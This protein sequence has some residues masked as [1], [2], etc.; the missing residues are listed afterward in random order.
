MT[1]RFVVSSEVFQSAMAAALLAVSVAG[2]CKKSSDSGEVPGTP[3]ATAP[4]ASGVAGGSPAAAEAV[5]PAVQVPAGT[6]VA[7]TPCQQIPRITNEELEGVRLELNAF[8]IDAYPYPNDPGKPPLTNV[9]RDEAE[10]LCSARGRRL[11]TELEWE[12]ACKGPANNTYPYGNAFKTKVC[13]GSSS[14]LRPAGSYDACVSAFGAK[15]MF[16]AVWEWTASEWG[17]GGAGGVATVR[18]GGAKNPS[19]QTRC[20][21]GQGRSPADGGNDVGFRCCGGT[22]NSVSVNLPID[23]QPILTAESAVDA[24]LSS[25]LMAV[26][27]AA[28]REV[29]GFQVSFD[30]VWRWHPRANEELLVVR[31]VAKKT[32]P[33]FQFYRPL[34]FHLCG[35]STVLSAKLRGPVERMFPPAAGADAQKISLQIETGTD[36]GEVQ[37]GYHYGSVSVKNPDWVKD[38]NTLS[39]SGAKPPRIIIR[40][41]PPTKK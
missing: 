35:N 14:L 9:P 12:R 8:D 6:L 5:G 26:L 33:A 3:G 36:K 2:C 30:R 10:K 7:G 28:M 21:N 24:T 34:V 17:R 40:P 39:P 29:P 37:L 1:T 11:C 38:G 20:A 16:G 27:P 31:Y 22:Q 23:S 15:A 41:P 25:R 32:G 4:A 18:G 19:L 13:D